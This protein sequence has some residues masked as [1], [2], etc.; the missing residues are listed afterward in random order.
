MR[1]RAAIALAAAVVLYL[2]SEPA[3][4]AQYFGQNQVQYRNFKFEILKTQHFDIYYYP[5][6]KATAE[7]LG[8]IGERWWERLGKLFGHTIRDRQPVMLYASAADFRQTNV[9]QGMGEGTGGVTEGMKRRIVMPSAGPLAETSH[10]LGHEL[11]HA[12]QYDIASKGA[13]GRGMQGGNFERLPLWFVEG[14]AEYLSLGPVDSQT[15]MWLRDAVESKK[16]PTLKQLGN[17]RFFPY[18]FGHAFWAYVGG[19]LGDDMVI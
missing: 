11:V 10:V 18:R 4:H 5:E 9:V 6:E 13:R 14:L 3:A 12:Y 15:A 17:P 8:R 19:L 16:L 7:Y 1:T 2:V